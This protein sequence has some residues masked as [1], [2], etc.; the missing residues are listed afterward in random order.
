MGLSLRDQLIQAGLLDQKK[1]KQAQQQQKR[2]ADAAAAQ[3]QR[4]REAQAAQAAQAAKAARDLE[5]NREAQAK[6][7]KKA[8]RAQVRQLVQQHQLP[9]PQDGEYFNFVFGEFADGKK[10][11]RLLVTPATRTA[12]VGG[13][14][15][16]VRCDGNFAVV[17][18]EI[19]QRIRALDETAAAAPQATAGGEAGQA[20]DPYKDYVVPDDIVW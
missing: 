3:E 14:L 9:R 12:L 17:P 8:R 15:A 18:A 16:I 2:G 7:D 5:L 19:A 11:K 6:A 13:T 4:K 1:A 20:E 10:I